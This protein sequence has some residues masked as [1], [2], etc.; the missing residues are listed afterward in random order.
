MKV[1]FDTHSLVWWLQDDYRVGERGMKALKDPGTTALVSAVTAFELANKFRI[2]KW[3]DVGP[4]LQ[5]FEQAMLD[6]GFELLPISAQ[7]ALLAGRLP[8][9]HR[10]P[11]DRLL[12]AQ[13]ILERC[14]II[15]NDP[16]MKELGA[17]VF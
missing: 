8:G 7:H 13:S 15:S 10:D 14:P 1:L 4:L 12:A 17:E 11:F 9:T 2:G 16:A 5:V 6:E 3:P